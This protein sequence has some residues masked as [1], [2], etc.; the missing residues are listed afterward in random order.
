MRVLC[1]LGMMTHCLQVIRS[2]QPRRA[3]EALAQMPCT[4]SIHPETLREIFPS[5]DL[6]R[7][8]RAFPS[9]SISE[10]RLAFLPSALNSFTPFPL[11]P[12]RSVVGTQKIICISDASDIAYFSASHECRNPP[13]QISSK[14]SGIR[15]CCRMHDS[16]KMFSKKNSSIAETI[17]K[18]ALGT[19]CSRKCM[20]I[21]MYIF[22][23][24]STER[25]VQQF[26]TIL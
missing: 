23:L 18:V 21:Q 13:Q 14:I 19:V 24:T 16:S 4:R 1:I 5:N 11:L 26:R 17:K 6:V 7:R 15:F 12:A 3:G 25:S 8:S 20:L 2:W 22:M 9:L 10:M